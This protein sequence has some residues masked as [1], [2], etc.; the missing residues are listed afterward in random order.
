MLW[1]ITYLFFL[2]SAPYP[3]SCVEVYYYN[4][5]CGWISFA[6]ENWCPFLLE[7]FQRFYAVLRVEQWLI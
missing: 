7:R 5:Q 4:M 6:L 1:T 3:Q 2:R